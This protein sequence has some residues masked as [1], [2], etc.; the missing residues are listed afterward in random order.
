MNPGNTT[1]EKR[2]R[3]CLVFLWSLLLVGCEDKHAT[4]DKLIALFNKHKATFEKLRQM[5]ANDSGLHRVDYYWTDPKDPV[6][7]G[8]SGARIEEYRNLLKSVGCRRGFM[9]WPTRPGVY[10][11]SSARG[12]GLGGGSEKGY[13]F[14][15]SAPASVV[16]NTAVFRFGAPETYRIYRHLEGAWYIYFEFDG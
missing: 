4:D 6:T 2:V 10:F 5:V 16:T 15:P 13:C 12:T 3:V 11:I 9:A 1:C 14:L 7:V 8:L